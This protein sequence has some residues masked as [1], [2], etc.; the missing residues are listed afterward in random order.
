MPSLLTRF[1]WSATILAILWSADSTHASTLCAGSCE[2]ST[3]ISVP[4][5][6]TILPPTQQPVFTVQPFVV[7]PGEP[8]VG[9]HESGRDWTIDEARHH[10]ERDFRSHHRKYGGYEDQPREHWGHDGRGHCDDDMPPH[11]VPLPPA[12][13]L[14][15]PALLL[16]RVLQRRAG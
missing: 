11:N 7:S 4:R 9:R 13:L 12:A 6:I 5:L 2:N 3:A 8:G 1:C 14:F 10:V 15:A 16:L